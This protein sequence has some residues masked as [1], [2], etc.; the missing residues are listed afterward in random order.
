VSI[1]IAAIALAGAVLSVAT[2]NSQVVVVPPYPQVGSSNPASPAPLVPRPA[3]TPCTVSLFMNMEFANYNVN[4]FSY[5]P[6]SNCPGPW[7]K[8]V[9]T[10]DFTVTAGTQY[11]RTGMFLIGSSPIYFGTTAEPA[12]NFS[13]SWHVEKDVTDYT[14][15]LESAQPGAAN[16]GNF[17]GV[18]GGINYDGIIYANAAL[19]F[20]P[21]AKGQTPPVVPDLI[22]PVP[23]G[24]NGPTMLSSTS[25]ELTQSFTLPPNTVRM[26]L[27]VYAQSQ[28]DDEFWWFCVP[29]DVATELDSC[30]NTAFRETEISLDGEPA[31]VAPVYPWIYT[32]GVDPNL[33]VPIV[34]V[35]TLDLKPY[36]VDLT[37]FA[38]V[39]NDNNSHTVG[40]SVFNAD[41]G[42]SAIATLFVYEDHGSAT[43]TGAL[44]RHTLSA[45]PTPSVVENLN[46]DTNGNIRGDIVVKSA[47]TY[48]NSGYVN[49][50]HGRV[51]TTLSQEVNFNNTQTFNITGTQYLQNVSQYTTVDTRMTLTENGG[52]IT[53]DTSS[54]YPFA[55]DYNEVENPNGTFTVVNSSDQTDANGPLLNGRFQP[56]YTIEN[57]NSTDTLQFD[58]NQ[59]FTGS[60]GSSTGLFET[61]TD[62]DCRIH[63]LASVDYVLTAA[64]RA[65]SG[66]FSESYCD[67]IAL[68][69]LVPA[70]A[71]SAVGG[72]MAATHPVA[73]FVSKLKRHQERQQAPN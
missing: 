46:V 23:A 6:P 16:L 27:D 11:D 29:N 7:A 35:Q 48:T 71:K 47:R 8:V 61:F 65:P 31:G 42:F 56:T 64:K 19:E 12:T 68:D 52:T 45:A 40:M 38:A 43:V 24:A 66:S 58:A 28:S 4:S 39:V 21:L 70:D 17:V 14:V 73:H 37:P 60:S 34:G 20:Y 51:T 32:G 26:Y 44:T 49:T 69:L 2:A 53:K 3:T 22:V 41:S 13:P 55:F 18:S 1:R 72:R 33:W 25:S 10:A 67:L 63:Y 59:V 54:R 5:A 57:V 62:L 15:L 9:F 50:S 36:R 30:G